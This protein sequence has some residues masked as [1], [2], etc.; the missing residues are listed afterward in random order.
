MKISVT[1]GEFAKLCGDCY[2]IRGAELCEGC[3]FWTI[4]DG[5]H[6]EL[7]VTEINIPRADA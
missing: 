2:R 7:F 1:R 6:V 5:Q 3:V 4:C